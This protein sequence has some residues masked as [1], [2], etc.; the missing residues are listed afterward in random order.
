MI[1]FSDPEPIFSRNRLVHAITA[2]NPSPKFSGPAQQGMRLWSNKLA[3]LEKSATDKKKVYTWFG[4]VSVTGALGME[5]P[6][7]W[8]SAFNHQIQ[9]SRQKKKG[10]ETHL[11]MYCGYF[12]DERPGSLHVGKI[13]EV[14]ARQN[15]VFG[16]PEEEAH[17]PMEFYQDLIDQYGRRFN[18]E[19]LV[20]YW[21]KISD[22]REI[23]KS[24]LE[25]LQRLT[26]NDTGEYEYKPFFTVNF[27]SPF[28]VYEQKE[29]VFFDPGELRSYG[30]PAWWE[31]VNRDVIVLHDSLSDNT[32][33]NT[34]RSNVVVA[35]RKAEKMAEC[36]S[37][38]LARSKEILFIDPYFSPEQKKWKEPLEAFISEAAK[39]SEK[40]YRLEYHTCEKESTCSF[41][42][43]IRKCRQHLP[44]I[45][46]PGWKIT[47]F[48]WRETDQPF[49]ARFILTE[50]AGVLFEHGLSEGQGD[51]GDQLLVLL[52][53]RVRAERWEMFQRSS[54]TY[55]FVNSEPVRGAEG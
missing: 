28:P 39:G 23:R 7:K 38:I 11:Y 35:P 43:L 50:K 45:L 8:A 36:V 55:E 42:E 25:N 27:N 16:D 47:I 41:D 40:K 19:M 9:V 21:F 32:D 6:G 46:P 1:S 51:Y 15:A 48:Q 5:D 34:P 3:Q 2:W 20:R 44:K 24:H 31:E 54:K 29:K 30:L 18:K 17:T 26:I 13:E 4:K 12:Y 22:I 33:S 52:T 49:H 14:V 37:A 53:P 10:P